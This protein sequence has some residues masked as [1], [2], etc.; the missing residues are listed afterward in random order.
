[1]IWSMWPPFGCVSSHLNRILPHC[2]HSDSDFGPSDTSEFQKVPNFFL[3]LS[4]DVANP[5]LDWFWKSWSSLNTEPS[6]KEKNNNVVVLNIHVSWNFLRDIGTLPS[7]FFFAGPWY[8]FL[9]K[10]NWGILKKGRVI[11][12]WLKILLVSQTFGGNCIAQLPTVSL[13]E[14]Q[15]EDFLVNTKKIIHG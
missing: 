1:M 12:V 15:K 6:M 2:A 4:V 13:N 11:R 5:S 9:S 7:V 3:G 14:L 10:K 8:C